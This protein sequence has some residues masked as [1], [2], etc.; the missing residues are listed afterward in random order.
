MNI[1]GVLNISGSQESINTNGDHEQDAGS[2]SLTELEFTNQQAATLVVGGKN[3]PIEHAQTVAANSDLS[4]L[5]TTNSWL[6]APGGCSNLHFIKDYMY[7][8]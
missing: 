5:P 4:A 2:D 3:Q 1:K 7:Y 6:Y 8:D